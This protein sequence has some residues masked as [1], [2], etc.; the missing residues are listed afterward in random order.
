M[1]EYLSFEK[2]VTPIWIKIVFW[3]GVV[4]IVLFGLVAMFAGS[5]Y[6]ALGPIGAILGMLLALFGWR[7]SCE[8][9]ILSFRI[10]EELVLIRKNTTR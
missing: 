6:G 8:L 4:V 10:Y 7:I 1:K 3:V 9:V 5:Q 2:F